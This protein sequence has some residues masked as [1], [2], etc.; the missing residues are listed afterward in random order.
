MTALIL[1]AVSGKE[2]VVFD[3]L[4][5]ML[6]ELKGIGRN[7]NQLTTLCNMGRIQCLRLDDVKHNLDRIYE[8]LSA[9]TGE[10]N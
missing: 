1:A 10:E 3:G 2:I 9:V 5:D 7:L 4:T 8:R 6:H